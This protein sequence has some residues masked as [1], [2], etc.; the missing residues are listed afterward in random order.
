[1]GGQPA[2]EDALGGLSACQR[3]LQPLLPHPLHLHALP[4]GLFYG[5]GQQTEVREQQGRPSKRL[6][7]HEGAVGRGEP[8][9]ELGGAVVLAAQGLEQD[10]PLCPASLDPSLEGG[11]LGQ[12]A[13]IGQKGGHLREV[14]WIRQLRC[15]RL[16]S[17]E[18]R[19]QL[20][21]N[22]PGDPAQH[23]QIGE[24]GQF[25]PMRHWTSA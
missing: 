24:A 3:P 6:D 13:A 9:A 2:G 16:H 14:A 11:G 17:R 19:G 18:K 5:E 8:L 21:Q 25:R 7:Q 20:P 12:D 22:A 4:A 1:M 10:L 15:C 23:R